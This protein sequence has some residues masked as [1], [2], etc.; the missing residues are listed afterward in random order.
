MDRIPL[1]LSQKK[2]RKWSLRTVVRLAPI[3]ALLGLAGFVYIKNIL[4]GYIDSHVENPEDRKKLFSAMEKI[5]V[6][7]P[8]IALE[9][10]FKKL[11]AQKSRALQ[12]SLK[13]TGYYLRSIDGLWGSQTNNAISAYAKDNGLKLSLRKIANDLNRKINVPEYVRLNYPKPQTMTTGVLFIGHP[14]PIAPFA[15]TAPSGQ[16]VYA[17]LR[18]PITQ[19]DVLAIYINGGRTY[20]GKAPLGIY[21]LVYAF[22]T[23]WYGEKLMFG[24]NATYKKATKILSFHK[25]VNRIYGHRITLLSVQNGNLP[26]QNISAADF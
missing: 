26:S 18:D 20:E 7:D 12:Y 10:D 13:E 3:I 14:N 25:T 11:S 5:G 21:E 15:I 19:T 16:E 1:S 22:G 4:P 17:K 6:K 9:E 8:L 24:P 23:N 2:S